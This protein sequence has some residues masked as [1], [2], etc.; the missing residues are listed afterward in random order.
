V[1]L[2]PGDRAR[3]TRIESELADADPDLAKR[4]RGWRASADPAAVQPGW[5]VAPPWMIVV[6]LVAFGSWVVTPAIGGVIAVTAGCWVLRRRTR[7]LR[8]DGRARRVDPDD[9]RG[10]RQPGRG[11]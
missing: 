8:G 9:G 10:H 7:H 2:D 4:L 11:W 6:F 5:S 3:L 1:A